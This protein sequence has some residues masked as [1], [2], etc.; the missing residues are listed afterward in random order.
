VK[1]LGTDEEGM[2]NSVSGGEFKI[3]VIEEAEAEEAVLET[4]E[5]II[6]KQ[7][8]EEEQM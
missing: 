3:D 1:A 7:N 2:L 4:E 8:R 6:S 5:P